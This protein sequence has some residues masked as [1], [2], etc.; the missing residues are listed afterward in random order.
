MTPARPPERH[1]IRLCDELAE[2]RRAL[3]E[4]RAAFDEIAESTDQEAIEL[5]ILTRRA[6]LQALTAID[7]IERALSRLDAGTYGRCDVCRES[8]AAAR[9]DALPTT[10]HCFGCASSAG[11]RRA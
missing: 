3:R 4:Y 8:I 9:L 5:R 2:Q 7:D 1:R 6:Q 10:V 11:E